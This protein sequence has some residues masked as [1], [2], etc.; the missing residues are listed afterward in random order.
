MQREVIEQAK[1]RRADC[2]S[3][4]RIDHIPGDGRAD[5]GKLLE[6]LGLSV[7]E[8][9][10]AF[11][12]FDLIEEALRLGGGGSSFRLQFGSKLSPLIN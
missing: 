8:S 4:G 1:K 6:D 5:S 12:R 2:L 10:I 9:S 3:P 7:L 11:R